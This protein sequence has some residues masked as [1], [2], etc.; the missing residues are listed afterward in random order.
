MGQLDCE[1]ICGTGGNI[2]CEDTCDIFVCVVGTCG[3]TVARRAVE[4]VRP[5]S[6]RYLEVR[7]VVVAVLA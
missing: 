7:G 1:P 5:S 3:T 2:D 6:C 4:L